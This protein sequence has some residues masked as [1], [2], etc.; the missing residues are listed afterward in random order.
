MRD[1]P[2]EEA[3]KL[4]KLAVE[5]RV[6]ERTEPVTNYHWHQCYSCLLQAFP[7]HYLKI[8]L[9]HA[10]ISAGNNTKAVTDA[11]IRNILAGKCHSTEGSDVTAKYFMNF[12]PP[13]WPHPPLNRLFM[14]LLFCRATDL[15]IS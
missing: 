8:S 2:K 13:D 15:F 7:A 6:R 5:T 4:P 1:Q 9:C 10:D 11:G 14:L 12:H 3:S